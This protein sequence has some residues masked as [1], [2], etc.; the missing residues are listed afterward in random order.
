MADLPL[1]RGDVVIAT[2]G[3]DYGKP[4]PGIVVQSN[5]FNEQHPSV[6][7]C[8]VS[9]ELTGLTLL[10]LAISKSETTGL[11]KDSEVMIDKVT[12]VTR[13]RI[14]QRIGRLSRAQISSLDDGLRLWLNLPTS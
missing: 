3:G 5:L 10:R 9:S 8:P 7:L 12:A 6:I 2:F 11:R 1:Q 4:R 13:S 14:K